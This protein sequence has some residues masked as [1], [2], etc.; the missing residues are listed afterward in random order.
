MR[1]NEYESECNFMCM[2]IN[3]CALEIACVCVSMGECS[4][5]KDHVIEF[6]LAHKEG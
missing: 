3:M 1:F 6:V 5:V 4:N 2:I